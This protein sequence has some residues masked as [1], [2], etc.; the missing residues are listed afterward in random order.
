MSDPAHEA[1]VRSY[2]AATFPD[3]PAVRDGRLI[4]VPSTDLFPGTLGNVSAVRLI[5]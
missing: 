4:A 2:L 1:A 3:M 5:A